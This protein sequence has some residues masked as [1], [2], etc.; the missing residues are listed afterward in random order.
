M[1]SPRLDLILRPAYR[2]GVLL[3]VLSI[4]SLCITAKHAV[5]KPQVLASIKPLALIAREVAGDLAQ[6]DTLLP[7]TASAHDYP[8]KMSDHRRLQDADLVL[9][10][11]AEL[12]SFLARPLAKLPAHKVMTSYQLEALFWPEMSEHD[13]QHTSQDQH[14]HAGRDPHIWLDPRNAAVIARELALRLGALEPAAA[15]QFTHNAERFS[16]SLL[17]LDARLAGQLAPVKELG[18][19]VYHEGYSHFV[20]HY[21]LHQLAYFTLVPE[22]RPGAKH[23]QE[24]RSV[25]AREGVCLFLEPYHNTQSLED[26]ARKMNL[27]LGWLDAIGTEAISSYQLLMENLGQSFLTCLADT[28]ARTGR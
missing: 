14:Q 7:V 16:A 5:A 17:A 6:V 22:R 19:A 27:R 2:F 11:G 1:G 15:A 12:E 24:L 18:F 26:M 13:H 23:L 28:A 21:G 9:W 4:L 20:S 25:L 8:L 10:V 3:L